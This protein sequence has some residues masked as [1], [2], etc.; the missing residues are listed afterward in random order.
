MGFGTLF[1]GYFLILNITYYGFTDIIAAL[2]MLLGLY[3]L[4]TVNKHFKLG[5]YSCIGFSCFALVELITQLIITFIPT[6]KPDTLLSYYDVIRCIA[7]LFVTLFMLMGMRD[8]SCEVGLKSLAKKCAR[9]IPTACA[10]YSVLLL[11]E[12][13]PV[14]NLFPPSVI[15]V[16]AL[17]A[18]LAL[19]IL[20]CINLTAI[21]ACYMKI[22][23]PEE[24]DAPIKESKFAFVNEYRKRQSERQLE[25]VK[26]KLEKHSQKR[27]KKK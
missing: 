27:N 11:L 23:M 21:Y 12:I 7:V 20:I 22:C 9:L 4:S 8:V 10:V 16:V 3:K 18:I 15:A 26:H 1:I 6:L 5:T 14:V 13:T 19:L 25:Y 2:I 17:F 24:V